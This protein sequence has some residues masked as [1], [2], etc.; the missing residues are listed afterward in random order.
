MDLISALCHP[1]GL[2][3]VADTISVGRFG[4]ELMFSILTTI[5]PM[6]RF[7][8]VAHVLPLRK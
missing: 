2:T 5:R 6:Q 4:I 1:S 7:P 3:P 8:G